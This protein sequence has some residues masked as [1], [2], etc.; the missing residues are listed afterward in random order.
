MAPSAQTKMGLNR[1]WMSPLHKMSQERQMDGHHITLARRDCSQTM[2]EGKRLKG[3][4]I[5]LW[6]EHE[7]Q[8]TAV[9][10]GSTGCGSSS[11]LSLWQAS[12]LRAFI[13]APGH[14]AKGSTDC[15][16]AREAQGCMACSGASSSATES[17]G[18]PVAVQG[19]A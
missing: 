11:Q 13:L 2:D 18:G 3:T 1:A 15:S 10:D 8:D 12:T 6:I 5:G 17:T 7:V 9:G 19:R 4:V 16:S 14:Q